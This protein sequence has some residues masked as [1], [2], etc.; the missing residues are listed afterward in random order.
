MKMAKIVRI[1]LF[2]IL[3]I[4]QRL[5]ENR[6]AF[7]YSRK[8]TESQQNRELYGILTSVLPSPHLRLRGGLENKQPA[9]VGGKPAATGQG[10]TGERCCKASGDKELSVSLENATHKAVSI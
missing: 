2:G 9:I 7:I 6:V 5:T 4:N 10:R 1:D 3:E 8:T